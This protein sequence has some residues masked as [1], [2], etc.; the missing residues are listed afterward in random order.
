MASRQYRFIDGQA[1]LANETCSKD[2][3]IDAGAYNKLQ[4]FVNVGSA[5]GASSLL[6]LQ[7]ASVDEPWLYVDLLTFSLATPG[8]QFDT[9]PD[10][11]RFLRWTTNGNVT[12]GPSITMDIIA[13][14]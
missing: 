9:A 7:H 5:G 14:E 13:K 1:L 12:G 10:F 3:N 4:V 11:L 8:K 2:R 6:I